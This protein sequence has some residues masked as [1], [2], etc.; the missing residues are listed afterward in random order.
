MNVVVTD[1]I[2]TTHSAHAEKA[3]ETKAQYGIKI[4]IES[5]V[6]STGEEQ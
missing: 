5:H 3:T 6:P 4:E 1:A 2:V